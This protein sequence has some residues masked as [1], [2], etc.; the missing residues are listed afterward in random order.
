MVVHCF[1]VAMHR[2]VE[3]L[4][5]HTNTILKWTLSASFPGDYPHKRM[6]TVNYEYFPQK[7]HPIGTVHFQYSVSRKT[8]VLTTIPAKLT[9]LHALQLREMIPDR[10]PGNNSH[11]KF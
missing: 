3:L 10:Q 5:K 8:A 6:L 11:N 2:M 1:P 4:Y 9:S 7:Y